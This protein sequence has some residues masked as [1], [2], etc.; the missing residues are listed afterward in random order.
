MRKMAII[1]CR[2]PRCVCEEPRVATGRHFAG[3]GLTYHP[4]MIKEII[5]LTLPDSC[6][7]MMSNDK[8][9]VQFTKLINSYIFNKL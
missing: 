3:G 2:F 8:R 7:K 9:F 6:T 4:N 1:V 5:K